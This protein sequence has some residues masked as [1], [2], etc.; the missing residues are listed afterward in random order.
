MGSP[1]TGQRVVPGCI[2]DCLRG[3][4]VFLVFVDTIKGDS[5]S[6]FSEHD[7]RRHNLNLRWLE[8]SRSSGLSSS[9]SEVEKRE[10]LTTAATRVSALVEEIDLETLW[11][12]RCEGTDADLPAAADTYATLWFGDSTTADHASALLRALAA[13]TTWF[14]RDKDGYSAQS[15]EKVA[16]IQAQREREAARQQEAAD[17]AERLR[18]GEPLTESQNPLG[19]ALV[20]QFI[21]Q[22][23]KPSREARGLLE[24]LGINPQN[25]AALHRILTR[26]GLLA[27]LANFH[28]ERFGFSTRYP[29]PVLQAADELPETLPALTQLRDLTDQPAVTIDEETTTS[30][31]D[32]VYLDSEASKLFIHIAHPPALLGFK[33]P[34]LD[35]ARRRGTS[36]FFPGEKHEMFP[37]RLA[38]D[39]LSLVAGKDRAAV[40]I[41]FSIRGDE[42]QESEIYL[43]RIRIAANLSYD[44]VDGGD[45]PAGQKNL[46]HLKRITESLR[47]TREAAGA[48]L[49]DRRELD[50]TW[51]GLEEI[52]IQSRD[53]AGSRLLVEELMV[54]TNQA[55]ARYFMRESIAAIYRGQTRPPGLEPPPDDLDPA[56]RLYR[57][58]R[59]LGG[60]ETGLSPMA[61]AALGVDVYLQATS[62]IRRFADLLLHMQLAA[63]LTGLPVLSGESLETEHFAVINSVRDA[64]QAERQRRRYLLLHYALR[65][66]DNTYPAIVLDTERRVT[67]R[68]DDLD[69]ECE[70][71][72]LPAAQAIPGEHCTVRLKSA[73]PLSGTIRV[74]IVRTQ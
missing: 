58:R 49:I 60:S 57:L 32:A 74:T 34:L 20:Q 10:T 29:D 43:S 31:D 33:S 65:H 40:T 45:F 39:L 14:R 17:A 26:S 38:D 55:F 73:D 66:P 7:S 44:G 15:A 12:F 35:E 23:E 62:P 11:S 19:M 63:H 42:I 8:N 2:C 52:Q 24:A 67:V 69:L 6:A 27:E 16:E 4:H 37:P 25:E 1:Q 5:V 9:A 21:R 59:L 22:A 70:C 72:D 56:L 30:Y 61:H 46:E 3:S 71:V 13:D 64:S 53:R 28:R 51:D 50:V 18:R 41:E 36:V 48:L 54:L 47:N 68:I